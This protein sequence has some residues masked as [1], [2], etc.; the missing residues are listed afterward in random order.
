MDG[1]G[2][3]DTDVQPAEMLRGPRDRYLDGIG[4]EHEPERPASG[5]LIGRHH[6]ISPVPCRPFRDRKAHAATATGDEKLP[7]LQA[8]QR[9]HGLSPVGFFGVWYFKPV[10]FSRAMRQPISASA[11]DLAPT[12][13]ASALLAWPS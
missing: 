9:F 1:G 7:A 10:H 12:V 5:F 6:D 2:I 13:A 3:V 8:P 4:V 11:G